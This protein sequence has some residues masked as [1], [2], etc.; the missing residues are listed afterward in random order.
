M[1]KT[2][3][4]DATVCVGCSLCAL[5]CSLVNLGEFNLAE[6]YVTVIRDDFTGVFSIAFKTTCR[7]CYQCA[8]VCPA[9][10]LVVV[11]EGADAS[12]G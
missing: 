11:G 8:L 5:T 12:D 10:A 7:R 4:I 2:L 9:G 3:A 1:G 6:A